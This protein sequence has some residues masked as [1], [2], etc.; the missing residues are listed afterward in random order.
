M[1]SGSTSE[2]N[3]CAFYDR[4]AEMMDAPSWKQVKISPRTIPQGVYLSI[5]EIT[6]QKRTSP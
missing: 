2:T 1:I 4:W 6:T 5:V 3:Q